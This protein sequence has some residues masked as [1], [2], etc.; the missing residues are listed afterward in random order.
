MNPLTIAST[1]SPL[2][3]GFLLCA[4]IIVALGP[5]NLFLLRQGLRRQH[6][7]ATALFSTLVDVMLISLGVGSLSSLIYGNGIVHTLITFGGVFFMAWCGSRSLMRAYNPISP[8]AETVSHSAATGLLTV[9]IAALSFSLLN[10]AKYLDTLVIIGSKSLLFPVD[11]RVV[12]GIG[13]IVASTF[14]FFT[15]TYGASKLSPIFRSPIAWRALDVI[16]GFIMLGIAVSMF[17]SLSFTA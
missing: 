12:F 16:S 15:L 9:I 7:F 5:Q 10:P 17:S 14:W 6:L 11:Q 3:Q 4:S 2:G 13:A 1:I 8:A